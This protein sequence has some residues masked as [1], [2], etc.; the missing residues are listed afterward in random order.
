MRVAHL[1][2][3]FPRLSETFV[4]NQLTG[5]IDRGCPTDI[6]GMARGDLGTVHPDVTHYDLLARDRYRHP[7]ANRLQR[8][9]GAG[10][11]LLSAR[12]PALLASLN[13]G[14]YGKRALNLEL[15]YAALSFQQQPPYD[16]LHAHFGN[17]GLV[18]LELKRL[19]LFQGKLVT[20]I[21]GADITRTL[22]RNPG[23]YRGLA[24]E[25]DLFL[26]ISEFFRDKLVAEGCPPEKIRVLRDGID[27]GRFA[28]RPRERAAGEP[29]RLLFIGR[30]EAKKGIFFALDAVTQALR[31]GHAPLEFH[32][33]GDGALRGE[34]EAR[35]AREGLSAHVL[36][37][38]RQ[39]Q[40]RVLEHLAK[41][42]L[43][44]AP[45][46]TS[47]EGDQEGIPNTVKE[48][49]AV[50]LPVLS[51]LHSG[52]PELVADGVSGY[53]VPENDVAAL[54]QRLTELLER[55]ERWAA[56]GRAGRAK[57]EADYDIEALNDDLLRL[58]EGLLA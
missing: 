51:T 52:I 24:R 37:H 31:A 25:G 13:P 39:P 16:I 26:P 55:P 35:V 49:M 57:V 47:P 6:F 40:D 4:L 58:Y 1:I 3:V 50:G 12:H 2:G 5:L 33:V 54:A 19:G 48:G 28:F 15:F 21:R 23:M 14:R 36:L 46:I 27:I 8:V 10:R 30:L 42:H 56:M 32:I 29:T 7:P 43:L 53:L 44:I 9:L 45:S 38:G 41:A 34:L 20:A 17:L 22:R 11:A 18:G